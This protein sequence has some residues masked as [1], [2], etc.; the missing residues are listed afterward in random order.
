MNDYK[1]I[2]EELLNYAD[3]RVNGD[4]PWDIQVHNEQLYSRVLKDGSIGFG[5]S[6]MD[7][8]WDCGQLD[9]LFHRII[10]VDLESK[11]KKNFRVLYGVLVARLSNPETKSRAFREVA[12]HYNV[13]N[14]LFRCMLDKRMVYS[15]GYWKNAK[16][17]EEAQEAKLDLVCKKVGMKPGMKLLDI[18][19]GWGSLAKYAAER[20]GANV[21]GITVSKEQA[22]FARESCKG[23]PVEIRL[24]D[25]R[26]VEGKFDAIVSL[27][28]FE[29]VGPKNYRRFMEIVH[30]CLDDEGVFLLHT[31]VR[32]V[33]G[34]TDPW[35]K[36]YIF[37]VGV[38]PTLEQIATSAERQFVI[39]DIHNFGEYYDKTLMAWFR[40]FQRSW[41]VLKNKYD[42][43][44]K[45]M[46]DYYMCAS[47]GCYR[48]RDSQ[49]LQI[50]MTKTG[51]GQPNCRFS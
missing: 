6:Y 1:K 51:R 16:N 39:E 47:A 9:E 36:K 49:V 28:M 31:I 30:G 46:W 19:C 42:N 8:W 24:Q 33:A 38:T 2:V 12:R 37:P 17:L 48:A 14:D 41:P 18:G 29:H 15:C 20:Y 22:E 13:G 43:V 35:I 44:F 21:V 10:R 11:I 26:D 34:E 50:V 4:R 45:R 23:L 25:Y 27:G 7:G 32:N 5:E 3:I 40:N